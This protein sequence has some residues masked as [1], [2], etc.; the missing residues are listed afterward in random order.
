MPPPSAAAT[1]SRSG[2]LGALLLL[3]LLVAAY[4][5]SLAL[6]QPGSRVEI[7][8]GIGVKVGQQIG[9]GTIG[10]A[11]LGS[12]GGPVNDVV[13]K[14]N[15]PNRNTG[16]RVDFGENEVDA[17]RKAGQLIAVEKDKMVQKKV[18]DMN[19][20]DYLTRADNDPK[21]RATFQR[22]G[23]DPKTAAG[24]PKLSEMI[25]KQVD[26]QQAEVGYLHGDVHPGNVR[27]HAQE[28]KAGQPVAKAA[29]TAECMESGFAFRGGRPSLYRRA[30][31]CKRPAAAVKA[32]KGGD[33]TVAD[34]AKRG[35]ATTAGK[36]KGAAAA[37]RVLNAPAA[38]TKGKGAGAPGGDKTGGAKAPKTVAK[39]GKKA[40]AAAA[41]KAK[42]AGGAAGKVP[43]TPTAAAA[44]AGAKG[45]P[46]KGKG[47]AAGDKAVTTARGGGTSKA[48]KPAAATAPAAGKTPKGGSGGGGGAKA[49]MGAKPAAKSEAAGKTRSAA[50]KTPAVS[51]KAG[52]GGG[53]KRGK[54]A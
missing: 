7:V 9:E 31:A 21:A 3:L 6:A 29:I 14:Q 43:K 1:R 2:V 15:K 24:K 22:V 44:G 32:A 26:R 20:S 49:A 16:A 50:S 41:R 17:T 37:T 47:G 39:V 51:N 45:G 48:P 23:E 8:D 36:E 30:G 46:G 25:W 33:K 10:V 18:G 19:L 34:K 12:L 53:S 28:Q 4:V 5:P 52:T 27:V 40:T 38:T 11:H 54:D 42:G 35:A 13:Y